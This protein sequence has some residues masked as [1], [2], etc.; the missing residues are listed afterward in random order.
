MKEIFLRGC[1]CKTAT[2]LPDEPHECEKGRFF[3]VLS[4][5]PKLKSLALTKRHIS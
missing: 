1:P 4:H 3:G 2:A 5:C